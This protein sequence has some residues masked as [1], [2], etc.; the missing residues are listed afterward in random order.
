MIDSIKPKVPVAYIMKC[1]AE[2]WGI[3]VEQM[4]GPRRTNIAEARVAAMTIAVELRPELTFG[5][6]GRVFNRDASSIINATI[7]AKK[8][9]RDPTFVQMCDEL[10]ANARAWQQARDVASIYDT[11]A[12]A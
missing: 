11:R 7:S 3:T 9:S 2:Q 10:R 12:V 5:A 4:R 8:R 6:I 1:A